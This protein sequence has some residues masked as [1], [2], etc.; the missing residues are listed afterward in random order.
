MLESEISDNFYDDSRNFHDIYYRNVSGYLLLGLK[1]KILFV[2]L[3]GHG[4]FGISETTF[5]KSFRE[6]SGVT[7]NYEPLKD[8]TYFT[9]VEG[10]IFFDLEDNWVLGTK[11]GD[12]N[13]SLSLKFG[14][15]QA[16]F[17]QDKNVVFFI[18]LKWG[19]ASGEK[20]KG[21]KK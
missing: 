6:S 21:K 12:Y 1:I 11:A 18:G 3:A 19:G 16:E 10:L 5:E 7:K 9:G 20:K 2:N 8:R 4:V 17:I 13:R 14:D 15:D